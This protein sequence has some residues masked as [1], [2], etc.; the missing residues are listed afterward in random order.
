MKQKIVH[1]QVILGGMDSNTLPK[2]QKIHSRVQGDITTQAT[3]LSSGKLFS[4]FHSQLFHF[5][6]HTP[7]PTDQHYKALGRNQTECSLNFNF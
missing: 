5:L 1:Y 4:F 6:K 7:P 2:G 3:T